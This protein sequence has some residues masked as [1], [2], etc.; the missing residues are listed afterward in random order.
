M[1]ERPSSPASLLVMGSGLWYLRHPD[2]GGLGAWTTAIHSTFDKLRL[3]QGQP[4]APLIAPWDTMGTMHNSLIPGMLPDG[5]AVLD[6][7]ESI[8]DEAKIVK[9]ARASTDFSL[10]D[11]IIFLPVP[12]PVDERLSDDRAKTI[13]HS[14]VEAMNADLYA[15]LSHSDPPPVIMP[16]VFNEILVDSETDDGLHFSDTI[17][18]KQAEMMLSWRCNDVMRKEGQ[19]G[20]CCRRYT[21]VRPM[22]ALILLLLGI[23]APIGAFVAPRISKS[24]PFQRYIPA[25]AAAGAWATFGLAM[26]YLFLADRTTIFLKEQK[27]YDAYVFGGLTVAALIAG[28]AT[29]KNSG[30]DTGFLNRDMTDEWKGWMQ[31]ESWMLRD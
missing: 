9:R 20:T 3:K 29:I 30:K 5:S 22:Q 21:T 14:D 31:S 25:G 4:I 17:M 16:S 23:W 11:A 27:D 10:A 6:K 12:N 8:K 28:L 15:R 26:A 19:E 18:N 1:L 24:S 2:S 13:M 7:D